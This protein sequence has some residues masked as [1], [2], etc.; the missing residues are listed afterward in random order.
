MSARSGSWGPLAL[1]AFLSLS[2][3]FP[4][5]AATKLVTPNL[6]AAA[7]DALFCRITNVGTKPIAV[8]IQIVGLGG[9]L[10]TEEDFVLS[11]DDTAFEAFSGPLAAFCRFLGTFNKAVVRASIDVFSA[12]RSLVALPAE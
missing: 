2:L 8:T 5:H 10:V 6:S 12:G 11:P 1:A 4:A 3:A 7:Q 9:F